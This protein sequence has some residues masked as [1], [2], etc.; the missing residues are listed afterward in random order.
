M[1]EFTEK[2]DKYTVT[3]D[4]DMGDGAT[5]CWIEYKT[6]TRIYSASLQC[7]QDM[8]ELESSDGLAI[9]IEQAVLDDIEKWAEENGY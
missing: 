9:K 7:A 2:F 4:N 3:M 5:G 1:A 6:R 8:G